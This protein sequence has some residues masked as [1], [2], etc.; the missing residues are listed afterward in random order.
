[1]RYLFVFLFFSTSVLA[2]V[3]EA[4]QLTIDFQQNPSSLVWKKIETKHFE[5]IF[6]EEIEEEA[7][8]VAY[9]VETAYPYVTRS[10]E[11][12]PHRIPLILQNQSTMSNGFVTLAPRR[13]EWYV[14]PAID[15]VINNTEWLKTLG[16]HE[17]RHVVQMQK[18]RKGVNF[19]LE[20]LLGEIGQAIGVG[21]TLPPWYLEGDAVGIETALTDGGRGR[22]PLFERD[23]RTL[24]LSGKDFSYD[25]AH[26]RS[27]KDYV[28]NHYVYGYYYTTFMRNKQGDLFLSYIA[29]EASKKSYNPLTFYNAYARLTGEDFD[30]FY[31]ETIQEMIQIWKEKFKQLTPTP[32]EVKTIGKRYGWTNYYFPQYTSEGKLIALKKGLSFIDQF[33]QIDG[34]K[35]KTLFYPG[36]LM[37]EYPYKIRGDRM[38]YVEYEIDPRWGYRDFSRVKVY[39]F[40]H[41][42]HIADFRKTKLRLAVLDQTGDYLLGV[43]WSTKQG[44]TVVVFDLKGK[45]VFSVPYPKKDVITSIDWLSDHEAVMVIKDREDKKRLVQL[46]LASQIEKVLVENTLTNLGFVGVSEG[47]IFLE[48]PES[49]IDNIYVYVEGEGLRQITSAA[50]GAYAPTLHEGK[51]VYNDYSV[52]GMNI[53]K[54]EMNWEEEQKSQDSFHPFYEKFAAKE[55]KEGLAAKLAQSENFEVKDYSQFKNALNF[56][57]WVILAPPLGATV[58]LQGISRDVLNKFALAAGADYNLNEKETM[59]FVSAA[60]SHYYPVFDLRAA[61]GGRRQDLLV[62]G[63]EREN[64]WEEGTAEAGMQVPW[65]LISGRFTHSF[66]ARAFSKVIKVTNKLSSDRRDVNDGALFSPGAEINY[67]VTSRMATRDILPQ[68]GFIVRL[69]AEEGK[70]ITGKDQKGAIQSADS[71]F[72]LPGLWYHHS[73]YHQVA[74]EKQRDDFYQYQSRVFYPRGTRSVFL[75]EFAKYS[76]NYTLPLLNPDWNLSRYLYLRR[77][78]L[79]LFYDYLNGRYRTTNYKAETYG[80]ETTFETNFFRFMYPITWGVRGSY[81]IKGREKENYELFLTTVVGVY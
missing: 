25:K 35:E 6:P 12:A 80:W 68:W 77:V 42:K 20:A 64:K 69:A 34:K 1:M 70:D 36:P 65:K 74:Y 49:G 54:K 24:L 15:P 61:Y 9:L 3:L 58:T 57:S 46:D 18:T 14:T 78:N 5:V 73:F 29:D 52:D 31:K 75:Q 4:P 19:Y 44:Q 40:K 41:K 66:S 13:S 10:L 16:I 37:N 11:A 23:L 62:G 60:W 55:D 53:V 50:F 45:K 22:L 71:R 27:Y 67:S 47:K 21:L 7:Q 38:S 72:F 2:N 48:D 32:Y 30:H 81:V 8:R 39:D 63:T 56:H 33:V 79:N 43:D 59:G 28:P 76:A 26:M 51:L 17:F